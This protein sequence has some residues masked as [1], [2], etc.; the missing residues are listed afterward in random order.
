M[1]LYAPNVRKSRA[2]YLWLIIE[3]IVILLMTEFRQF[4]AEEQK[5]P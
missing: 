5:V 3:V 2:F 1:E 4:S